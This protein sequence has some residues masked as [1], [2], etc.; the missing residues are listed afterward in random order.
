MHRETIPDLLAAVRDAAR[1]TQP[2]H[3]AMKV[4]QAALIVFGPRVAENFKT[5][6]TDY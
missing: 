3:F 6:H 2:S 4:V 5:G 1:R